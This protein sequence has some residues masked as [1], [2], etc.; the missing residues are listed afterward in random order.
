M[1]TTITFFDAVKIFFFAHIIFLD[2]VKNKMILN[3]LYFS[4]VLDNKIVENMKKLQSSKGLETLIN[5]KI[6]VFV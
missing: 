1:N 3:L 5:L 2:L 4:I 6:S